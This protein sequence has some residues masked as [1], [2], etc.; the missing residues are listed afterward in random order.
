MA[1]HPMNHEPVLHRCCEQRSS[2][3]SLDEEKFVPGTSWLAVRATAP[4]ESV[5]KRIH[6]IKTWWDSETTT[7]PNGASFSFLKAFCVE[8]NEANGEMVII[9]HI[10]GGRKVMQ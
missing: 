5:V 7:F 3:L 9:T 8:V 1:K 2:E 6:C 10:S 4:G